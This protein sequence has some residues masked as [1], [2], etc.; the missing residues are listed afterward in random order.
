MPAYTTPDI[1]NIALIGHTHCGKTSLTESLL[2]AGG[3]IHTLGLVEKGTTVSDYTDEEKARGASIYNSVVHCD[4]KG[5][6]INIIDTP[7]SPDFA[8]QAIAALYA[9]DTAV[10][11]I[12]AATGVEPNSRRLFQ[13]AGECGV[14]RMII[15]NRIDA[16][17]VDIAEVL[18]QVQQTFGPECM[19]VNLPAGGQ[20]KTVD[21]FTER[22]GDSDLGPVAD[23]HR[24][25]VEQIV[26]M[27]DQMVNE[28]F[29]R[30]DIEDWHR[31]HEPFEAALREGHVVPIC[32]TI[33]RHHKDANKTLGITELLDFIAEWG[34]NPME[35]KE[36]RFVKEDGSEIVA[37]EDPKQPVLAHTFKVIND[38]FGKMGVF[39]IFQGHV[40]K[41]APVY[42]GDHKKPTKLAHI[43]TVQGKD[44][45]EID[46]GIAGDICG[47]IKVEE[48]DIGVVMQSSLN[49]H[50]KLKGET[51][52]TPMHGL[53]VVSKKR[54]DEQKIADA[55]H[56]IKS[57]DPTFKIDRNAVTHELVI[58]GLGEQHLRVILDKMQHK[59]GLEIETHPPKIAY[60]ETISTKAEG[61]HRHKKQT[62]GAGQFGEVYLRVVP[63]ERGKGFEFVDDTFGG[64]P[65]KQYLPAIEKGV[66]MVLEHGC[67]AGYPIQD[68]R[69]EVYDG[70]HHDVDSKE[71]AFISAGKKAFMDAV[72]KAR[73]VVLEPIVT[74]E[75]T[76]PNQYMGDITGDLSGKRGRIQT[77]DMLAGDLS[78]IKALV[79]LSE[80]TNYQSQLKSVTAGQGSYTMELSHY[81]PVPGNIQAQIVAAY[82]PRV[83]ED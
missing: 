73:P 24:K 33:A 37:S 31:L 48:V 65:P 79:P 11:V 43:Y 45:L 27:D 7:G 59:F 82:K 77:T 50:L 22:E 55:L 29:E 36:H 23:H 54:G 35:A 47:V 15:I 53:A 39:R 52:P 66:R 74:I 32:F 49:G 34:P 58:Y 21:C 8:G 38:R 61:H 42:V 57:E 63:L 56:K 30:G 19:P 44:H 25:I 5:K 13:K 4:Y 80:V 16:E 10:L 18:D 14:C 70:K 75:I 26:E 71:I 41:E 3:A 76:V 12:N 9:I 28:Y 1:R 17:N 20:T 72:A 51:Y 69:V 46:Q 62:G 6:R 67:V 81:D 78:V 83:E 68:V 64:H 60:K 2:K 40:S